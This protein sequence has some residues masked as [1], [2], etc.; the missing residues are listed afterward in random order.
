MPHRLDTRLASQLLSGLPLSMTYEYNPRTLFK[1]CSNTSSTQPTLYNCS[2]SSTRSRA[3]PTSTSVENEAE[4]FHQSFESTA[5]CCSQESLEPKFSNFC[6]LPADSLG[7]SYTSSD[8]EKTPDGPRE[9]RG[10]LPHLDP[11]IKNLLALTVNEWGSPSLGVRRGL[12]RRAGV[13]LAKINLSI[14]IYR[15]AKKAA[16]LTASLVTHV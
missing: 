12:A 14:S 13:T 2:H 4:N 5:A 15:S 10:K 7:D 8:E 3:D 16:F 9:R 11:L 1:V 6:L